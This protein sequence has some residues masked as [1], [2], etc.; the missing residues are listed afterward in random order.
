MTA[1]IISQA[2][3][4]AIVINQAPMAAIVIS[5]APTVLWGPS[6]W[7]WMGNTHRRCEKSE[8]GGSPH[9]SHSL[10]VGPIR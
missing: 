3:M 7:G 5:Q 9:F 8:G 2:P 6:V 10:C 4:A 1:I